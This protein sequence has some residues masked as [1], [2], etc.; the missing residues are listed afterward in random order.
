M[1]AAL[2][3]P[4]DKMKEIENAGDVSA[5][6]A[7]KEEFRAA[8]FSLVWD[9][10]CDKAGKGVGLEWLAKVKTYERDVLANR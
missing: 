9:Y 5:R 10:Y 4:I 2:L 3:Q 1:L 7:Y 6:L 8:P